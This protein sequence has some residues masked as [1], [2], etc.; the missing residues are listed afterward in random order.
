VDRVA[1][2]NLIHRGIGRVEFFDLPE[3]R[4]ADLAPLLDA[5]A[6]EG[7]PRFS[8]HSPVTRTVAFPYSGVTCF[9]LSDDAGLREQSF[10]LL[11]ATMAAAKRWGAAYVVSHLTHGPTDSKNRSTALRLAAAACE[12]M[13]ALSRRYGV[14]LDVEFAAYTDAFHQAEDFVAAVAEHPEL[15]LCIDAGHAYLG[16]LIRERDHLADIA[17]LAP[18]ARSIHLWNSKG[19]EHTRQHHHT[20]LHPSQNPADGWIDIEPIVEIVAGTRA[21]INV[22]FEYPVDDLTPDVQAGYDWVAG[23]LERYQTPDR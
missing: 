2:A 5:F 22:V 14:P 10:I 18:S 1:A 20:P 9:Y 23:I 19:L 11:D 15:G 16:G 8:F 7:R 17:C 12:R 4:V 13:A 21:E 3:D 6:A